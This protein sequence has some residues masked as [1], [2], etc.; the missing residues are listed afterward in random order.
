MRL[1]VEGRGK[2]DFG[3]SGVEGGHWRGAFRRVNVFQ[4][5]GEIPGLS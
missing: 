4:R 2:E 5:F 1:R 3:R